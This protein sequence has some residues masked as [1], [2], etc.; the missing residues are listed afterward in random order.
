[1]SGANTGLCKKVN[2]LCKRITSKGPGKVNFTAPWAPCQSIRPCAR[3]TQSHKGPDRKTRGKGLWKAP[4][5]CQDPPKPNGTLCLARL[6]AFF[7]DHRLY[8]EHMD[9][10]QA[11]YYRNL[12]HVLTNLTKQHQSSIKLANHDDTKHVSQVFGHHFEIQC[13]AHP[14]LGSRLKRHI[15]I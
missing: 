8:H 4:C 12:L 9:Q 6:S 3:S 5:S 2:E 1:M 7:L 15:K 14:V 10:A 13:P 11:I